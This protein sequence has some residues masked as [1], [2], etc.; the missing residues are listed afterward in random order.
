MTIGA[1]KLRTIFLRPCAAAPA[2]CGRVR[3]LRVQFDDVAIGKRMV[4]PDLLSFEAGVAPYASKLQRPRQVVVHES[5]DIGDRLAAA[6]REGPLLVYRPPGRLG[7][8]KQPL[9]GGPG[10]AGS[11]TA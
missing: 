11:A 4:L 1:V 9:A 7:V 8:R 3:R 10:K 2:S 6:Q 5:R